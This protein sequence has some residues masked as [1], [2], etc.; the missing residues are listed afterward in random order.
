MNIKNMTLGII[1]CDCCGDALPDDS[2]PLCDVCG[3]EAEQEKRADDRLE[4]L[5]QGLMAV[6]EAEHPGRLRVMDDG[7]ALTF[8]ALYRR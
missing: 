6:Y 2:G 3:L 8:K 5:L 1:F 7:P 4:Q